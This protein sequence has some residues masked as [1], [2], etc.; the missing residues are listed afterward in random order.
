MEK[1][2]VGGQAEGVKGLEKKNGFL[3]I[4]SPRLVGQ[5]RSLQG[6]L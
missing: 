5:S 2:V 4:L 1:S 6:K 3:T